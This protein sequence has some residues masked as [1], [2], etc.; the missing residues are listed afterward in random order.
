MLKLRDATDDGAA[1]AHWP[2]FPALQLHACVLC[3][4]VQTL[5]LFIRDP[6]LLKPLFIPLGI[7]RKD[8]ILYG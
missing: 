7:R 5:T 1:I 2:F 6:Y 4:G 3:S 8:Q